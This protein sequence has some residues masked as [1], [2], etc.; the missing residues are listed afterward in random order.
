M[1]IRTGH[2]VRR[3]TSNCGGVAV[4]SVAAAVAAVLAGASGMARAQDASNN[5]VI[6]EVTVTG[7]RHGIESA[8]AIKK[9]SDSITESVTAED[10]GKL[11][12]TSIAESIARLPGLAAQRVNGRAQVISIRGLGPK[13]GATLLNGR[14]MV[15][16]G[17]N[18]SVELDQFPSELINSA[19][20]YKTPDASIIGQGLSG[21]LDMK[22]VRPLDFNKTEIALN[23]RV[24][25]N[26]NGKLNADSKDRGGRASGSYIAQFADGKFGLALGLAY[27]DTPNQEEHYKSWWWADTGAWGAPLAGTPDG[28]I[29]LQGFEAGAASTVQ[30]R[31]GLMAVLEFKPTDN[32]HSMVDL[33]YSKFDQTEIRRTL[34][35]GMDAWGGSWG[36]ANYTN[37]V[38][39][40]V[41]GDTI[42]TGGT[43]NNVRPVD[44]TSFN[45]RQDEIKAVGWNTQL[46]M[47]AWTAAADLSYS[48]ADRDEQNAELEAGFGTIDPNTGEPVPG[49]IS[50]SDLSIATGAGRSTLVPSVAFD[51]STTTML[52]DPAAWGRDGRS[53]FPKVRDEQQA[54]RLSLGREFDGFLHSFDIGVNYAERTKNMNRTEV[55]YYLQNGRTPVAIS[56]DMLVRPTSLE[57]GGIPGGVLAFNFNDVLNTYYDAATPAAL[58]AA[59]GRIWD[60]KE[61]VTTAYTKVGLKFDT[62]V[63]IHGNLGLQ[64]VRARQTSDGIDWFIDTNGVGGPVPMTGGKAYT[65]V[66]PSLNLIFDL[67]RDTYVRLGVAKELARPNMEDMRAGFSGVGISATSPRVWSGSGGNPWIEPWRANAYD[68]SVEKYFGKRSYVAAAYFYKDLKNFVYSQ[69]VPYDFSGFTDPNGLTPE[70]PLTAPN[71]SNPNIGQLSTLANGHSGL[72]AGFELSLSLDFGTFTEKLD[73]FGLVFNGSDT[74]SSLHEENNPN[75][76]LDGLSGTVTNITGYYEDH[77]FSARISQRHRSRFVTNVRGVFGDNVPSAIDAESIVD[78]QLGYQFETGRFKGLSLLFQVNNLTNEPYVTEVGVSVGS[79]NP[80]ATMPE[81]FTTYGREYLFGFSYRL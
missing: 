66:L 32:L 17:D 70:C 22:T 30:E 49:Q 75:T 20:V 1:K 13:Y 26:S 25:L 74:R 29:A 78:A 40:D 62:R 12:D 2:L 73:G 19:T 23:G 63:P 76:P 44:L 37:A 33:Y 61:Y 60:V 59:P 3:R 31:T 27:L 14:E 5:D 4:N 68:I 69:S 34:M 18:R 65:D 24:N 45:K 21:T 51:D 50:I 15:S 52:M 36:G 38:T 43:V 71:C 81:R 77:G 42:V 57:F 46:A 53:Q 28:S 55:Y 9:Q 80:N 48:R 54:A 16:T 56:S 41:N 8:I 67:P 7:I 58:D 10:I 39:T 72:I 11:P 79:V 47:G 64:V 6:E 35:S